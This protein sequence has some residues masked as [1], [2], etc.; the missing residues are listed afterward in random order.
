MAADPVS[1]I[2]TAIAEGFKL[3]AVVLK[4]REKAKMVAAIQ[5][6]EQYI[7]VDERVGKY[8]GFDDKDVAKYKLHFRKRFFANN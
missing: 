2:A 3:I 4:G 1:G 5:A 7:F 6:A 8:K